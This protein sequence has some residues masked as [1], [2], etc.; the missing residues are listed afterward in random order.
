[1]YVSRLSFY[2]RPGHTEEVVAVARRSSF[3]I[4]ALMHV[5]A[6]P[7]WADAGGQQPLEI[8]VYNHAG[9]PVRV[10]AQA[11]EKATRIFYLS[12]LQTI[13]INRL[14]EKAEPQPDRELPDLSELPD[15]LEELV[16]A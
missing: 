3:W 7:V 13:W 15:T 2:T 8:Y 4:V 12:G 11:E 1:M 9:V 5:A 16:A 6:L 10:L 14:A